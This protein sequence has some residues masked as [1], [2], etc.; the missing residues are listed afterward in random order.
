MR[1]S[2]TVQAT[3]AGLVI[4]S[5]MLAGC[6]EPTAVPANDEFAGNSGQTSQSQ[7]NENGTS[8][9]NS[10]QTDSNT[11]QN[12][13]TGVYK[14]GTYD[15][16]GQYGP[17]GEDSIDVSLT[18]ADGTITA[19]AVEGHPFTSISKNHQ[20]N[21]I[22]AVDEVVV[23]KPLKGLHLDTVAGASWTTDAFNK[24]LDVARSEASTSSHS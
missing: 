7:E 10:E 20:Q 13:D 11:S 5:A 2:R 14:D 9:T 22:D 21:F 23:G 8:G 3:L 6:G 4:S 18:L 12:A 19:V 1:N 15:I 16:K 24:A 17:V